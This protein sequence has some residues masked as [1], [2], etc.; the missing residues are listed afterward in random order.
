MRPTWAFLLLIGRTIPLARRWPSAKIAGSGRFD[1]VDNSRE[2]VVQIGAQRALLRRLARRAVG[3]AE[4]P[5]VRGVGAGRAD[6]AAAVVD[7]RGERGLA[8]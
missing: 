3:G 8:G 7:E 5:Q 2:A 1:V 4:D 6:A